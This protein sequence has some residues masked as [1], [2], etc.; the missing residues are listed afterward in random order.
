[1][2]VLA[3]L[4]AA[5]LACLPCAVLAQERAMSDEARST[6]R[7]AADC[8]VQTRLNSRTGRDIV[9]FLGMSPSD[10]AVGRKVN[11]NGLTYQD[12]QGGAPYPDHSWAAALRNCMFTRRPSGKG[13]VG[14]V[15]FTPLL[16]RGMMFRG[17]YLKEFGQHAASQPLAAVQTP[18]WRFADGDA[19][20]SLQAYG[21]CVVRRD[22]EGARAILLAPTASREE[23][24]AYGR[25]KPAFADC[26]SPGATM[27]FSKAVI[28]GLV[29]E[30]LFHLSGGTLDEPRRAKS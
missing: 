23:Q 11:L 17:L 9:A 4:V 8:A 25:M 27:R 12:L 14:Q 19:F 16:I 24:V 15:S 26:L 13:A 30:G 22:A 5:C 2:R 20:N 7:M 6:V 3:S 10:P 21:E 29:A 1:M 18:T 28:E